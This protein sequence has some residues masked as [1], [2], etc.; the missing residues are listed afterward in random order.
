[1][2]TP[3]EASAAPPGR[4]SD[5]RQSVA[6]SLEL[7]GA[8]AAPLDGL[9]DA[10]QSAAGSLELDGASAVP[11]GD[12]DFTGV[13]AALRR[14]AAR[15]RREAAAAG[16][17]VAVFRDGKVVLENPGP[18][19]GSAPP[20]RADAGA[21]PADLEKPGREPIP[22]PGRSF[23]NQVRDGDAR[24]GRGHRRRGRG[25]GFPNPARDSDG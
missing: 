20:G 23:P 22:H 7:D 21:P 14:A 9:S 24:P 6:G 18:E 10:R 3:N 17:A 11:P 1:M 2:S 15:A 4:P 13:G 16:V 8:S 25:P 19:P 5:A 12:P